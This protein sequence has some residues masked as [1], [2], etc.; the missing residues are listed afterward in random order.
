MTVYCGDCSSELRCECDVLAELRE[1]S[2]DQL[3]LITVEKF[4]CDMWGGDLCPE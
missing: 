2:P 4:Q 1:V 3:E